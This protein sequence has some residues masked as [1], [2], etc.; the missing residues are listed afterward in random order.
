MLVHRALPIVSSPFGSR[1]TPTNENATRRTKVHQ[2]ERLWAIRW[3]DNGERC[4]VGGYLR[5]EDARA[6][7]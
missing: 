7:G 1:L 4:Y 3:T 5:E 2:R 6:S